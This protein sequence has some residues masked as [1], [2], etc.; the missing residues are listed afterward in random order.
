MCTTV[1]TVVYNFTR[2]DSLKSYE[3]I[4]VNNMDNR[5]TGTALRIIEIIKALHV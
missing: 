2:A 4:F 3:I 1:N 5:E